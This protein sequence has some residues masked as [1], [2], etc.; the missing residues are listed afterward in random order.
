MC[1]LPRN[2]GARDR[3]ADQRRR[4]VVEERSTARRSSPAA[5]SRPSSRRAGSR[6]SQSGTRLVLEVLATESAKPSSN[7][8]RLASIDPFVAEM[9]EPIREARSPSETVRTAILYSEMTTRPLTAIGSV[10]RC[11]SATPASVGREQDEVERDP[12]HSR[13]L[14]RA[15]QRR[16]G[17]TRTEGRQHAGSESGE[18]QRCWRG[19]SS[20]SPGDGARQRDVGVHVPSGVLLCR[21]CSLGCPPPKRRVRLALCTGKSCDL[22]HGK[23]LACQSPIRL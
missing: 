6:G 23:L 9:S 19:T 2:T 7:P 3:A 13:R 21:D 10:W 5:R 14:E 1:T 12:G 18:A 15:C 17:Q 8:N 16:R 4:D 20:G 11:S 22:P